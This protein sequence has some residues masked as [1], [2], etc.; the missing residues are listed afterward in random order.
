MSMKQEPGA[1]S[2]LPGQPLPANMRI[3]T[4]DDGLPVLTTT[5]VINTQFGGFSLSS[6]ALRRIADRKGWT[7]DEYGCVVGAEPWKS[8]SDLCPR[9]DADLVAVVEEM[10][11][12]NAGAPGTRLEIVE[13]CLSANL[14]NYDGM[15]QVIR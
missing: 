11:P 1:G 4:N 10:G 12:G 14:D 13:I 6:E 9:Y 8:V 15:E 2:I 3:I 7:L 5:A